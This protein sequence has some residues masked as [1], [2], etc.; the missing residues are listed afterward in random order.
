MSWLWQAWIWAR[1]CRTS[2]LPPDQRWTTEVRRDW[3]YWGHV[4]VIIL[5]VSQNRCPLTFRTYCT[6][7][8]VFKSD[9]L[10]AEFKCISPCFSAHFAVTQLPVGDAVG[11]CAA[12]CRPVGGAAAGLHRHPADDPADQVQPVQAGQG[13]RPGHKPVHGNW[14]ATVRHTHWHPVITAVYLYMHF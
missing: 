13:G 4:P 6:S 10:A 3:S 14:H 5:L 1:P 7:A 11:L 12:P 9:N 8:C 2:P